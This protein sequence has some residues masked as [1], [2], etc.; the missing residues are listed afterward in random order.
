MW[1]MP[2]RTAPATASL[3]PASY[4]LAFG[5]GICNRHGG[6]DRLAADRGPPVVRA[7]FPGARRGIDPGPKVRSTVVSARPPRTRRRACPHAARNALSLPDDHEIS[8]F[9]TPGRQRALALFGF[10]PRLPIRRGSRIPRQSSA[11][12]LPGPRSRPLP[13]VHHRVPHSVSFAASPLE[14]QAAHRPIRILRE[15]C[16]PGHCRPTLPLTHR[17]P[18]PARRG[19]I[20]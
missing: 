20:S 4:I 9:A 19:W 7:K 12:Q 2:S 8:A 5:Q 1:F 11:A 15:P 13:C 16:P 17:A 3:V 14:E 6:N 18:V 10:P